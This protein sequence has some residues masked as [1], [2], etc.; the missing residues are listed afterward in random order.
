MRPLFVALIVLFA[1]AAVAGTRGSQS[2]TLKPP[3]TIQ[4][5]TLATS[6]SASLVAPGSIVTLWADVTPKPS[7][8]VYAKGA[9]AFTPV[10][11]VA[12]PQ[13]G[14]TFLEPVYPPA[15]RD[16]T[17]GTS[18]PVPMYRTTFRIALPVRVASTLT[19][20]RTITVAA[21]INYQAC[22][23]RLCY[24]ETS[25]PAFWTIATGPAKP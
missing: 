11:L 1:A 9:S 12:T 3:P 8:H 24:P 10:A 5:V 2:L 17:L 14:V 4:H 20:G 15:V 23:D 21:A 7:V 6:S 18:E 13:E 16:R 25:I 19:P 22:D